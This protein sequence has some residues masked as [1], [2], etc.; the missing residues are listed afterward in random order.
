MNDKGYYAQY[1][2]G[3]PSLMISPRFEALGEALA[4]LFGVADE[5]NAAAI[6]SKSPVTDFG[7]TCIYPQ[8]PG[9]PP[10]HNNGIWP[11]VQSYWNL[12]A[13]KTG[14]EKVLTHGLAAIYRAAGLFLTNYEN[15]VAQTGDFL[16]TEINSDRMLWSMA[17]NLAMVH[18]VFMGMSF[19]LD[20]L[21]FNPVVP[22][23]FK[24]T[25]TLS[26][27]K[28]RNSVLNIT[29]NGYGNQIR[30]M[31]MDGN[32]MKGNFIPT[33]L[34]GVHSISIDLA[35]NDFGDAEMNKVENHFSPTAP[36]PIIEG[37]SIRWQIQK[38]TSAYNIYKDGVLINSI[39]ASEYKIPDEKF[40]VYQVSAVDEKGFES[41]ASAPLNYADKPQFFELE[42]FAAKASRPYSNFSGKG[43]VEISTDKNKII[44]GTM[45]VDKAG[46]YLL[47]VR[48]SNG[49]GPWNTDNKCAIR[50]LSINGNEQGVLVFP[51]RGKDEWSDWGFSNSRKVKLNA[52]ANKFKISF[53]EWN[54]NMNVDVNTAELDYI[55]LIPMN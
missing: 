49:S 27:F 6:I 48:Y 26:N 8:I 53:E 38:W 5:K 36:Q 32:E 2:Y 23:S 3:R 24:G 44:E 16:G 22:K 7:V 47:D 21:H 30:S 41:F 37:N 12:A 18:R 42:N 20:G 33:N 28:Y 15:M 43:F 50:T 40:S 54:N 51:Q 45:T 10:Y 17:G 34:T 1:L 35:D 29:V 39:M 19:E 14:N 31:V 9:I 25:K 4:V 52:G 13:A 11:F 46:V 55:R